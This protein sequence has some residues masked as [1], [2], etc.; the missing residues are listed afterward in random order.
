MLTILCDLISLPS[1]YNAG[2]CS[3]IEFFGAHN[4]TDFQ[5]EACHKLASV[6]G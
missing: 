4:V 6:V 1:R 3:R 5:E 2:V